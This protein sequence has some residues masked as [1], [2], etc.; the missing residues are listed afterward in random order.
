ME[1]V[2]LFIFSSLS[3]VACML[4]QHRVSSVRHFGKIFCQ[5]KYQAGKKETRAGRG[6]PS[7]GFKQNSRVVRS[8][9]L[10][11]GRG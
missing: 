1:I 9:Y 3:I 10:K 8:T 11:F 2:G 7:V 4:I 5:R 6:N